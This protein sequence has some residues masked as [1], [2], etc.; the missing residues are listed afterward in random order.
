MRRPERRNR[1]I[2]T[3]KAG[4]GQNNRM[5]IPESWQDRFG[6]FSIYYERI[7]PAQY[8]IVEVKGNKVKFYFED[9]RDG[10]VY[11]FGIDDVVYLLSLLADQFAEFP[12]IVVFRQP[13]NKQAALMP[14]WGRFAYY[15]GPIDY[16]DDSVDKSAIVFE[17]KRIGEIMRYPHKM[18]LEDRKE[19]ERLKED[20]HVFTK[21][22]RYWETRLSEETIRST[23]LY[24][25]LI[26]ELGHWKQYCD[27][28]KF[29]ERE[30]EAEEKDP[31]DRHHS[32]PAVEKEQFAHRFA[33][34][35]RRKLRDLGLIP[36]ET[37]P[38]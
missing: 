21:E 31:H 3:A 34:E 8:R 22:K 32:R 2:G 27:D 35:N 23:V 18:S 29:K 9:L 7:E 4:H 19:F 16:D 37:P 38:K 5:R 12:Q 15:F 36:F 11:G 17:A 20:G 28:V 13:T 14:V 10:Y 25:T 6:E 1:N 24:R 30:A 26:H 33:D